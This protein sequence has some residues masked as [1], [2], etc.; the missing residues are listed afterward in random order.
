MADDKAAKT[1]VAVGAGALLGT[2]FTL[3]FARK[4]QASE[5]GGTV[6]LDEAAMS[7]L[8]AIAQ[9]AQNLDDI[10]SNTNQANT[11]LNQI[12]QM[13][14]IHPDAAYYIAHLVSDEGRY[15]EAANLLEKSLM[16]ANV[17]LY[18]NNAESMLEDLN[19]RLAEKD[20]PKSDDSDKE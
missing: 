2:A 7:V 15:L 6:S 9:E 14:N 10:S 3:F 17:F 13:K 1:G 11:L 19:E 8:L 5:P 4:A 12:A 20:P 16:S 18:R